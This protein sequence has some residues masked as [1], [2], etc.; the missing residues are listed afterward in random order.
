MHSHFGANSVL[1]FFIVRPY[2]QCP[3]TNCR[4][5]VCGR[6]SAVLFVRH[7]EDHDVPMAESSIYRF[8]T[9]ISKLEPDNDATRLSLSY[10][11][12]TEF[13]LMD[14]DRHFNY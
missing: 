5:A 13:E 7:M 10:G 8:R 2:V 1:T 6:V 11:K 12:I 3:F 14:M 4:L 9:N